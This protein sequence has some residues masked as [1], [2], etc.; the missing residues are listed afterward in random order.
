MGVD[1]QIQGFGQ[2]SSVKRRG[3][4]RHSDTPHSARPAGHGH[5]HGGHGNETLGG[6]EVAAP[7]ERSPTQLAGAVGASSSAVRVEVSGLS[8]VE[9]TSNAGVQETT[10]SGHVASASERKRRGRPPRSTS[11]HSAQP[12][13]TS[14]TKDDTDDNQGKKRRGRPPGSKNRTP[15]SSQNRAEGQFTVPSR[16]KSSA[17]TTPARSAL[18]NASTPAADQPFAVI[19]DTTSR[20]TSLRRADS[21]RKRKSESRDPNRRT[22]GRPS[23]ASRAEP[24]YK[25]YDCQWKDCIAQLHNLDTLRKHVR[26]V[27][28]AIAAF[29]GIPCLWKGCGKVSFLQDRKTGRHNRVHQYLDFGTEDLWDEHMDRKHL[30]PFAWDL[31]DGPSAGPSG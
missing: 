19:I 22:R 20:N 16:P 10:L 23:A 18:R 3:P 29:G 2:G 28:R 12:S 5:R 25:I 21:Q 31:G 26:K 30:E 11:T 4:L 8:A 15:Q 17:N 7:T 13:R 27:H 14:S 6:S 9:T 24:T 1:I